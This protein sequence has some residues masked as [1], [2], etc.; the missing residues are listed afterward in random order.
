MDEQ[1]TRVHLEN[2]K[3]ITSKNL[4]GTITGASVINY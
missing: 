3:V 2:K 1:S 4:D